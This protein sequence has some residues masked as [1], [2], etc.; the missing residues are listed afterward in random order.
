MPIHEQDGEPR[1][2]RPGHTLH[3]DIMYMCCKVKPKISKPKFM[4]LIAV[5]EQTGATGTLLLEQRET[6][7]VRE[8]LTKI[9]NHWKSLNYEVKRIHF[10][11]EKAFLSQQAHFANIGIKCTYCNADYHSRRAERHIHTI[12]HKIRAVLMDL[13]YRLPI[14]LYPY[15][16]KHIS[17]QQNNTPNILCGDFT[18]N[19]IILQK[20]VQES[21]DLRFSFGELVI[22]KMPYSSK[23]P[24]DQPV[25]HIGITIG[26]CSATEGGV[27][28]YNPF[29]SR[30]VTRK[31]F[32]PINMTQDIIDILG[33]QTLDQIID[34]NF[35]SEGEYNVIH[36]TQRP[37]DIGAPSHVSTHD[38]LMDMEDMIIEEVEDMDIE[39][40]I[41]E[42]PYQ[43]DFPDHQSEPSSDI[44]DELQLEGE[45]IPL[46]MEQTGDIPLEME[47]TGDESMQDND[48]EYIE[49]DRRVSGRNTRR[50]ARFIYKA[51]AER[52]T[53][54]IQEMRNGPQAV[55]T[56]IQNMLEN[57]VFE[58]V[59][60]QEAAEDK[61]T[62]QYI[63]SLIFA[64]EKYDSKG[65]YDKTKVR[66]CAGGHMQNDVLDKRVNN[67]PT[68][69]LTSIFIMLQWAAK[70]GFYLKSK[71]ITAAYLNAK[72]GEE[73][74]TVYMWLNQDIV[75]ALLQVREDL[76]SFKHKGKI[77]TRV[78]KSLYGLV[79]SARNWYNH[80]VDSLINQMKMQKCDWDPCL[81]RNESG[82][83]IVGVYVDDLLIM[84]KDTKSLKSFED[85]L[86]GI[87]PKTTTSEVD[88]FSFLQMHIKKNAI[89]DISVS[90]ETMV[91]RMT[92]DYKLN[93][94]I[95][96][97]Y[98]S[99]YIELEDD[100]VELTD[101]EKSQLLSDTMKLMYVAQ[102]TRSDILFATAQMT[103]VITQA[104]RK[105]Q[106]K[107]QRIFEY[108]KV[109]KSY[110]KIFKKDVDMRIIVYSDAS[111]GN[112]RNK[113]R[114]QGSF[115][116]FLDT[117]HNS[118]SIWSE[119]K[120][121]PAPTASTFIAEANAAYEA[122]SKIEYIGGILIFIGGT[123]SEIPILHQDNQATML[124]F[125]NINQA[126]KGKARYVDR[127]IM[128][129]AELQEKGT[130]MAQYCKSADMI[131]DVHTKELPW[132]KFVPLS[133]ITMGM[134]H[135][136]IVKGFNEG[137]VVISTPE[138][139]NGSLNPVLEIWTDVT[140]GPEEIVATALD[141]K[142]EHENSEFNVAISKMKINDSTR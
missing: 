70:N 65:Q 94:Y 30:I 101:I 85:Q 67:S 23:Q 117:Y 72:L 11:R 66:I 41:P 123:I 29:T 53:K 142:T 58:F 68:L 128:V 127:K 20:I 10:D 31:H 13:E 89:G 91:D 7:D 130:M 50:P 39:S 79:Q 109:T 8:A 51:K 76:D 57:G 122:S 103:Q 75:A 60:V 15:L 115:D 111:M 37:F 125:K 119:S 55:N 99:Q 88:D 110:S 61:N 140:D 56:E 14:A 18:P 33:T 77:L 19:Q 82:S 92:T 90:Q 36:S 45:S 24:H 69:N 54:K 84:Y 22:A 71:D 2:N 105:D 78:K 126:C 134:T 116:V 100:E 43:P 6:L 135:E 137:S 80:I 114:A 12:R 118:A 120:I 83:V 113:C 93:P 34:N 95:K 87:Y 133:R 47:Q 73:E 3:V 81:F 46:E 102:R 28:I 48:N 112:M 26:T 98:I 131:S 74:T 63:P 104:N 97:P 59:T 42:P 129:M 40:T 138:I 16:V 4:F 52:N 139:K 32:K 136:H 25:A 38:T 1:Y 9:V 107:T 108:L 141:G 86:D 35:F 96:S 27:L 124:L 49:E 121:Q 44:S 132:Q 17:A 5:D 62:K 64:I 106:R 21:V